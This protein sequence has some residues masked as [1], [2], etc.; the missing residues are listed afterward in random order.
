MIE[1]FVEGLQ[2]SSPYLLLL[3]TV[4][5]FLECM[6]G[7]GLFVSGTIL[8]STATWLYSTSAF[9][10]ASIVAAAFLGA[11]VGDHGGYFVG[12]SAE[13]LILNSKFIKK[14]HTVAA[15][16]TAGLQRSFLL[17]IC[18]GRFIPVAR[19]LTPAMAGA[20]GLSR[21][22]FHVYDSIACIIWSTGLALLMVGLGDFIVD[23]L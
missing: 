15:R 1:T 21:I 7:I 19:S 22:R 10:P 11:I 5:A 13:P 16:I 23:N 17:S 6:V 18:I 3:I 12:R 14:H 4:L 20:A 9:S 2:G 8:L